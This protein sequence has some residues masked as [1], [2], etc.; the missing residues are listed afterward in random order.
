MVWSES[1]AGGVLAL[2]PRAGG[3]SIDA[4]SLSPAAV[5]LLLQGGFSLHPWWSLVLLPGIL[6]E[7]DHEKCCR[8]VSCL[9]PPA[10]TSVFSL[11]SRLSSTPWS[12]Y[13]KPEE[14]HFQSGPEQDLQ[15]LVS[16]GKKS[17]LL[18]Q[19]ADGD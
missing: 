8:G 5:H 9:R 6:D 11:L 19:G 2:L 15:L 16:P 14:R 18:W 17:M 4:G 1:H 3:N 12:S 7:G 13:R 10:A